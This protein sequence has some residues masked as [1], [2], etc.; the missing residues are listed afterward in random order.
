MNKLYIVIVGLVLVAGAWLLSQGSEP[1]LIET[2]Q[3]IKETVTTLSM[4]M[5]NTVN[6]TA[7]LLAVGDREGTGTAYRS[8]KEGEFLHAVVANM[9]SPAEGNVY[10]GWLVMPNPLQFFSTGV[11]EQNEQGE[12]ILE[13][14]SNVDY[15]LHTKIVITEETLVDEIPEAHILQG[16]F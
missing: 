9:P 6:E 13:Y 15:P 3:E 8:F 2:E 10:E 4:L 11:M 14:V 12:W 1:V 7:T 5:E 16:D